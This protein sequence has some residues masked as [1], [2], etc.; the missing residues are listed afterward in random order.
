MEPIDLLRKI[1]Q[2][3]SCLVGIGN[4]LRADDGFGPYIIEGLSQ[5]GIFPEDDLLVVEDVPENFAF[6]ISRKEATNIIFIDAIFLEAPPGTVVFGPLAELEGIGQIVS[7]HKLSLRLTARV[8]EEAGKNVFL[9]G[10]VPSSLE[11]GQPL[12][13]E[14]KSVADN[15]I[16][17][18]E[19]LARAPD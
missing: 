11:F 15:L 12:S 7:T 2:Q 4:K 5:K 8:I 6:P 19:N 18:I 3:K 1:L 14:I 10:V 17:L 9:L 13:P 16:A